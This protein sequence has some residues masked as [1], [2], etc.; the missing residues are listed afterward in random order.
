MRLQIS[1][2][3]AQQI[4]ADD[5]QFADTPTPAVRLSRPQMLAK[6][7][8]LG[9]GHDTYFA[10]RALGGGNSVF[11]GNG[12]RF[13]LAA[14]AAS[15]PGSFGEVKGTERAPDLGDTVARRMAARRGR[16]LTTSN[17]DRSE[18]ISLNA[19]YRAKSGGLRP[20]QDLGDVVAERMAER[21]KGRH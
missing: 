7:T 14:D 11:D 3:R 19:S 17:T 18:V 15:N 20:T 5:A 1:D 12:G 2:E 21:R 16:N 4:L 9:I 10:I 13:R 8:E 6:L